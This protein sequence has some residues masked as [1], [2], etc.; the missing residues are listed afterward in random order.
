MLNALFNCLREAH[1]QQDVKAI[2][3]TG[4]KGKFSAGFD[5]NQ[6]AKSGGG[7]IDSRLDNFTP[8]HLAVPLL[9]RR[10]G[11]NSQNV[12]IMSH[13]FDHCCRI[14]DNFCALLESGPKPTVAAIESLALGGGLEVALACNA[15][16]CT[17]GLDSSPYLLL[18]TRIIPFLLLA[19]GRRR[20]PSSI[21][22][23]ILRQ[24]TSPSAFLL[25]GIPATPFLLLGLGADGHWAY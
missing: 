20:S 11:H 16:L 13:A 23:V 9:S 24:A 3:V 2:V 21:N 8:C 6:F 25:P 19:W 10:P 22:C 14:N 5:I 15:R 4:S 1:S 12:V 17:P 18:A 7:G